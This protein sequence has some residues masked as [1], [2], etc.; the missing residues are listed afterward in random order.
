MAAWAIFCAIPELCSST[1]SVPS[2]CDCLVPPPQKK[3]DVVEHPEVFDHIG[4]LFDE[5]P[6]TAGLPFI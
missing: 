5:P 2:G 4:L 6:G 3:A 1:K